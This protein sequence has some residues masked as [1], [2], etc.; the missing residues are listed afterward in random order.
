MAYVLDTTKQAGSE[1]E[2]VASLT[3]EEWFTN[4]GLQSGDYI[5]VCASN[6]T[7]LNALT[8]TSSTGSWTRLNNADSAR[9][10]TFMRSQVWWHRYD[11]STLPS[12]PTAGGGS[13]AVWAAFAWVVR[14]APDVSDQTWMDVSA[15]T[16]TS[17]LTR[18]HTIGSVTTTTADC[19]LLTVFTSNGTSAF[20]TPNGF[21]GV[22]LSVGRAGDSTT[23]S[24][25][26]Q[27][28]IVA[29]RAQ[30]TAGATPT[31]EYVGGTGNGVRAQHWTIA[32]KNKTGGARPI[33]IRNP[34]TRVTDFLEDG[35]F[36]NV[37]LTSLSTIH[38]TIDGQSTFA[39]ATINGVANIQGLITN[40]PPIL[41]WFRQISI[42]PPSATTGVSGVRWDLSAATDYTAGLWCLFTQRASNTQ[43]SPNGIYH[44]FE[45]SDGNWSVYRF[46]NRLEG[47]RYNSLIRHLPDETRVDGSSTPPNLAAITKRGICYRQISAGTGLRFFPLRAEC[48]QPFASPLTLVGGG[49]T[50]P[51]TARTVARMLDSGAAWRL[52]FSQGQGQQ[53]I[54]MPY[55]LGDGTIATYVDDEA[56]ALEYPSVGGVL[57]YSVAAGR[58]EIRIKASAADTV[59]LDAGIKGTDRT[60]KIVLDSASSTSATYGFAGTFLGWEITAI[61]GVALRSGTYIGCAKINAKGADFSGSVL[62]A[63]VA[64]DAAMR[65]EDGGSAAGASFT[66]GA[67]TYAVEVNGTGEVDLSNA[68][69]SGYTKPLN[70][71]AASG[72]VTI[73]LAA[74]QSQPAFDTAG[75]TVVFDQPQVTA[76]VTCIDAATSLPISG[77]RVLVRTD[78]NV[79][80]ISGTTNASGQ[81]SAVWTGGTPVSVSGWARKASGTPNYIEGRIAGTISSAGFSSTVLLQSEG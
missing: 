78:A 16:D 64:A 48:I 39:P 30:Y 76:T 61:N 68:V 62:K 28:I 65:L 22:D 29:S 38:A 59:A 53:V 71:L 8:L 43:E 46:L 42:T 75:A 36:T 66:K 7:G 79:T 19:L 18:V 27:R 26:T 14:D 41:T 52:A 54:T 57:G 74:G 56:Q 37:S 81:I 4:D 77:V 73:I 10:A 70:I 44:Y 20:E 5:M 31:Y 35:T 6:Q 67:E 11:G 80:V 25:P 23:V 58:Q 1:G 34:P 47:S 21:W 17:A 69:F 63:S 40:N 32:I 13:S 60:H 45:D 9:V 2:A 15:R 12:A 24:S 51:I 33:G 50:N 49:P 55:Q 72:T 3:F